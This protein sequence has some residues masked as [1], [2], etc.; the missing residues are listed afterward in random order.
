[1]MYCDAK[2]IYVLKTMEILD[3]GELFR[4]AERATKYHNGKQQQ[5]NRTNNLFLMNK[6][7]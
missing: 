3:F 1:M 7:H 6:C 4:G 5:Q 2:S